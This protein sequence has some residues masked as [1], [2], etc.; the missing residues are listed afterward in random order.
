M[1]VRCDVG[2]SAGD[3]ML[4]TEVDGVGCSVLDTGSGGSRVEAGAHIALLIRVRC[5]RRI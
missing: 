4:D 2:H 3:L 1:T 5:V